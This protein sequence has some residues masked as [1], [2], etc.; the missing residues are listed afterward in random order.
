VRNASA[1][2][3]VVLAVCEREENSPPVNSLLL[4]LS[5]SFI[6]FRNVG[7]CGLAGSSGGLASFVFALIF[8]FPSFLFFVFPYILLF[9][10][11]F[12]RLY[13]FSP[14]PSAVPFPCKR[15]E[16]H[17]VTQGANKQNIKEQPSKTEEEEEEEIKRERE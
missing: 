11:F 7:S 2:T 14:S 4:F 17:A 9:F 6:L 5:Y 1:K 10:S 8:C 3:S 16:P 15:I 12:P 13:C